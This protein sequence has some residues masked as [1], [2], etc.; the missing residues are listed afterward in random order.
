[1]NLLASH[2]IIET[3]N[4]SLS[5]L[6]SE[7]DLEDLK[8]N[9]DNN[10]PTGY[11]E[12]GEKFIKLLNLSIDKNDY[13]EDKQEYDDNEF[14][15]G[16]NELNLEDEDMIDLD[17]RSIMVANDKLVN[18]SLNSLLSSM[19]ASG[20][21]YSNELFKTNKDVMENSNSNSNNNNNN[22]GE[23]LDYDL[24]LLVE[25][26]S[27]TIEDYNKSILADY[28]DGS[29]VFMR[30]RSFDGA[31]KKKNRTEEGNNKSPS[32][33]ESANIFLDLTVKNQS[34][35]GIDS[36]LFDSDDFD[37]VIGKNINRDRREATRTDGG[38]V[39]NNWPSYASK[40]K[41]NPSSSSLQF[42]P[43]NQCNDEDNKKLQEIIREEILNRRKNIDDKV[44]NDKIKFYENCQQLPS[45]CQWGGKC[46]VEKFE[47]I[48][49]NID[50]DFTKEE[51]LSTKKDNNA[52]GNTF[53][54]ARCQCPI[55]RGGSLCQKRKYMDT[56]STFLTSLNVLYF[57]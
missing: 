38:H 8:N 29:T 34:K 33:N 1:M 13:D 22:N 6:V 35:N 48:L 24:S 17:I 16:A 3:K 37:K 12:N 10:K 40:N 50:S 55:G 5:S 27:K 28:D 43:S 46:F 23:E 51:E 26:V 45:E 32:I 19:G 7:L 47:I 53:R 44:D 31:T 25:L 14:K 57:D 4:T 2:G 30:P 54:F 39:T 21:H 11:D 52:L 41:I 42:F 56:V 36:S 49:D 20:D 9:N 15:D 18:G